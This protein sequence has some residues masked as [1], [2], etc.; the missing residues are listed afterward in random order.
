MQGDTSLP[1]EN[2]LPKR[3]AWHSEGDVDD[4]TGGAAGGAANVRDSWPAVQ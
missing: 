3:R 1:A 2:Q 4:Q